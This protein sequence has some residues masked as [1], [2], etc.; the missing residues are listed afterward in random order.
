M[1]GGRVAI[2]GPTG[3]NFAAGMS[4]G[5][6]YV[7]DPEDRLLMNCN[8]EM[9][10]LEPMQESADIEELRQLVQNHYDYTGSTVAEGML[11]NWNETLKKFV[12]V[13]PIDYKRAMREMAEEAFKSKPVP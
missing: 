11:A 2:L 9:V 1:T 12:K 13:I 5:L 8:I 6:A 4:G 10:E 7:Y 3:R